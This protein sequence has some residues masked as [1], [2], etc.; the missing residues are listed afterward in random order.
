MI[1]NDMTILHPKFRGAFVAL[2]D[3]LMRAHKSGS[4]K[5]LF[6]VF[7]TVRYADRQDH[8]FKIGASKARAWKSAHNFGLAVDFV[9]VV[10]IDEA[11]RISEITGDATR[12]G[13]SWWQGHDYNFLKMSAERVG[14]VS[15]IKW[16]KVHVECPAF[17]KVLKH[18]DMM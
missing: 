10:D 14:L 18:F 17:D 12:A 4:T 6:K 16:D 13:W 5:T 15:P 7:E 3:D 11:E 1:L 9:P 2:A 8:L